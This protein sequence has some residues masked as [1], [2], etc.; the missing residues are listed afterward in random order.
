MRV[1]E[2]SALWEDAAAQGWES[3]LL[4]QGKGFKHFLQSTEQIQWCGTPFSKWPLQ[5]TRLELE[6][7]EF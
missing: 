2:L 4:F 7:D 3:A 1:S 5:L 6:G